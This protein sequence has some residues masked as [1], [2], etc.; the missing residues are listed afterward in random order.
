VV[1]GRS[2]VG[3]SCGGLGA[4]LDRTATWTDRL[5][6]GRRVVAPVG[7]RRE[8][9]THLAQPQLCLWLAIPGILVSAILTMFKACREITGGCSSIV[10]RIGRIVCRL[11]AE[12]GVV[13]ARVFISYARPDR[14][15]ADEVC[16]WLRAAGHEPFL[17]DDLGGGIG[18]D[19]EWKQRLYRELRRVDAVIGW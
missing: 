13:V 3:R 2:G 8:R 16:G 15:I 12:L 4:A 18:V 6:L 14:V 19:E 10:C 9:H 5:C 11:S 17:A 7:I 1:S